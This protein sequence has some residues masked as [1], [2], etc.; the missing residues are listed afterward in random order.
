MHERLSHDF[1][2]NCHRLKPFSAK[3]K[4]KNIINTS[5]AKT[6]SAHFGFFYSYR[7]V[8]SSST[9]STW[10]EPA[11]FYNRRAHVLF[12]VLH[13][14]LRLFWCRF[15][16]ICVEFVLGIKQTLKRNLIG[17]IQYDNYN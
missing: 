3:K 16:S 5:F 2:D 6:A 13:A 11:I 4:K 1:I 10:N 8:C 7:S 14:N 15:V 17:S 12:H 9:F